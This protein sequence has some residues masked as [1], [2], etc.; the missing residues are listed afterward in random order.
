[1][2]ET[3]ANSVLEYVDVEAVIGLIGKSVNRLIAKPKNNLLHLFTHSPI[4]P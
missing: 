4:H 3:L 2:I 1:M